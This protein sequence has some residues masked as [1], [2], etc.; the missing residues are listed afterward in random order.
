MRY[1]TAE[2]MKEFTCAFIEKEQEYRLK[3]ILD[4]I[5]EHILISAMGGN[6]KLEYKLY[7][8]NNN[9]NF[10]TYIEQKFVGLGYIVYLTQTEEYVMYLICWK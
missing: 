3:L 9:K 10:L 1:K 5:H 2:E 8:D 4:D 6:F 7:K